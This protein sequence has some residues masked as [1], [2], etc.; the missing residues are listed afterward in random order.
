[1]HGEIQTDGKVIS[2]RSIKAGNH[3]HH[4]KNAARTFFCSIVVF[5]VASVVFQ[6]LKLTADF[7]LILK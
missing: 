3:A 1:M 2:V 6:H 7:R 4:T 5:R